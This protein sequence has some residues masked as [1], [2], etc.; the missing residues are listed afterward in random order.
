MNIVIF[1]FL[2]LSLF[3]DFFAFNFISFSFNNIS[4]IFPMFFLVSNIIL[5]KYLNK[6]NIYIFIL[7]I[8]L[9]SSVILN[10]TILGMVLFSWIYFFNKVFV[11]IPLIIR[12]ILLIFIYDII[13]YLILVLFNYLDFSI[14]FYLYKVLRS[15]L[16]NIIYLFL[17]DFV[18]KKINL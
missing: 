18:L 5:F 15:I 13:F 17:G 11:S 2:F 8:I 14:Y 7:F 10:N 6:N 1:C 16:I 9:Y 3:L 12:S 4:F